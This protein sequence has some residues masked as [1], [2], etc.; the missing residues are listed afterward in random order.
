[1]LVQAPRR[2]EGLGMR[3]LGSPGATLTWSHV[4]PPALTQ[5]AE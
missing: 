5:L 1:M 4:A 3:G 2:P